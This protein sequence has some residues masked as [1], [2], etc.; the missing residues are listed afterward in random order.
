VMATAA[1]VLRGNFPH[2]KGAL[3]PLVGN[4]ASLLD[5]LG[6]LPS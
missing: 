4:L 3:P 1:G 6:R 5:D 2:S